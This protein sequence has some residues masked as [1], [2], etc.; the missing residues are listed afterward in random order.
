MPEILIVVA[1]AL[2]AQRLPPLP[3]ARVVVSGIGAVNAAL[4]TQR[5]L[6]NSSAALV[7]SV[8]IGGAYP[9]S[10]LSLAAVA[11]ASSCI[12]AGLGAM[13][14]DDFLDLEQLGFALIEQP[15]ATIYNQLPVAPWAKAL[16]SAHS[17][18]YGPFLTLETVTGS[19]ERAHWLQKRYPSA[20]V[21][22]MEGA[23]VAQAA[24][25]H[26]IAC[27]EL[28]AISNP[29]GPRDRSSWDIGGAL[30]ALQ[31]CLLQL[32]PDI[33]SHANIPTQGGPTIR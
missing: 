14:N 8:G 19:L 28:R 6:F 27:L 2:E 13:N 33:C 7:I 26:G 15:T 23:G 21:E 9:N 17:L 25:Q 29:V 20:L 22:G 3:Y 32:W 1:T 31:L 10:G 12:Y 5:A 30:R 16:A 18:A 4:A 24:L 11:I